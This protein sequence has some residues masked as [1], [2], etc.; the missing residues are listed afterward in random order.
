MSGATAPRT[1]RPSATTSG[2]IPSPA[3]TASRMAVDPRSERVEVR[4]TGLAR[5]DPAGD[6]AEQ[7]GRHGAVHGH[8]HQGL[9]AP[10]G[11]ADLGPRDV[12]PRLAE[13]RTDGADD[14]GP[15]GV[16]EEEQVTG[17]V[18]V[19]V[20]AEHLG[21]LWPLVLA[22]K[23]AGDGDLRAVGHRAAHLDEVAVV[24]ALHV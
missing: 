17:G 19:H 24:G 23:P 11:P 13:R 6:V 21:Q 9:T 10:G 1:F 2:P 16:G 5:A 7:L 22:E 15:V 20:E 14:A 3:I 4:G 8:G 18:E 12:D